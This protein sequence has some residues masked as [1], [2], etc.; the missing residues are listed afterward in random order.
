MKNELKPASSFLSAALILR[1]AASAMPSSR[2][3]GHAARSFSRS[4]KLST[5]IYGVRGTPENAYM[6]QLIGATSAEWSSS[7][8]QIFSLTLP[9]K[10]T[11]RMAPR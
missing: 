1:I 5:G 9:R 8:R 2:I 4:G 11:Y 7:W 6:K 10:C 3:S